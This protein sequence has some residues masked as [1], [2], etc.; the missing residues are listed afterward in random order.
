MPP[1]AFLPNIG[2]FE[3]LVI[4]VVALLIFGGRLP[5][6]GRNL[7]RGLSQFR[8]GVQDLKEEIEAEEPPRP[9]KPTTSLPASPPGTPSPPP[10]PAPSDETPRPSPP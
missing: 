2:P 5:E 1:P 4:L 6:V 9:A 7:G 10:L 8:K 3:M